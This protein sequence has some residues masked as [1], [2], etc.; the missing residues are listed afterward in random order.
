MTKKLFDFQ[1][2]EKEAD[3]LY[4]EIHRIKGYIG[5]L[6]INPEPW[7]VCHKFCKQYEDQKKS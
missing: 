4:D 7:D 1:F 2:T 6:G 5:I 3:Y